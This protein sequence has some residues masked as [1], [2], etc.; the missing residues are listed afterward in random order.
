MNNFS[1][2]TSY[3]FVYMLVNDSLPNWIKIGES[4][5]PESRVRSGNTW[6]PT[7]WHIH[8]AWET[9]NKLKAERICHLLLASVRAPSGSELFNIPTGVVKET[10]I[11][12]DTGEYEVPTWPTDDLA[13]WL[14]REVSR[15]GLRFEPAQFK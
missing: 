6:L 8:R 5:N 14:T 4:K 15:T 1:V 11:C 3:E 13:D 12:D 7:R 2:K 10:Y 9:D